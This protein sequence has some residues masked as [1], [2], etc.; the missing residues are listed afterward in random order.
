MG[1]R[2]LQEAIEEVEFG[3]FEKKLR[4]PS[5]ESATAGSAVA[6]YQDVPAPI[7]RA[8]AKAEESLHSKGE[9]DPTIAGDLLRSSIDEAHREIVA[10]LS[11]VGSLQ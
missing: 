4:A 7:I 5:D 9:F 11:K 10:R 1:L 3:E 8:L 2:Q 6:A